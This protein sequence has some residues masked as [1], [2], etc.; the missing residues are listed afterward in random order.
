MKTALALTMLAAACGKDPLG[1]IGGD[2][3][4]AGN[5]RTTGAACVLPAAG[6]G[7]DGEVEEWRDVE[8]QELEPCTDPRCPPVTPAGLQLAL[9]NDD[10]YGVSLGIRVL[11]DGAIA[12]LAPD[13]RFAVALAGV[14][15][16]PAPSVDHVIVGLDAWE[17]RKAGA[18]IEAAYD[19][20]TELPVRIAWTDDGFEALVALELLPFVTGVQV[21][22]TAVVD[23]A[24]LAAGATTARGCW[25]PG[26]LNLDPCGRGRP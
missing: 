9:T 24:S 1:G 23:G 3:C 25:E 18:V 17:Y 14:P 12:D 8:L 22:P 7:I 4:Y 16:F 2:P 5:E 13:A 26:E 21:T 10:R 11:L 20:Y 19:D 15:Q 6:V